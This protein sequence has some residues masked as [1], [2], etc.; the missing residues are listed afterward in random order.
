MRGTC[1]SIPL[2]NARRKFLSLLL[3]LFFLV[4]SC[5][6]PPHR[7]PAHS[8]QTSQEN[9]LSALKEQYELRLSDG[10]KTQEI[11]QSIFADF[12]GEGQSSPKPVLLFTAGPMGA[13]KTFVLEA[14]AKAGYY[15]KER[16]ETV[17]PDLIEPKIPEY[18]EFYS[19]APEEAATILHK[20]S[21]QIADE[22][23]E[24]ALKSGKDIIVDGS[25]RNA[26]WYQGEFQRIRREY[27]SYGILI[28]YT[29]ASS[30]KILERI[31]HR[32]SDPK[33]GRFTPKELALRSLEE[34]EHSIEIL[35]DYVDSTL[36]VD[37]EEKPFFESMYQKGKTR[38]LRIEIPTP[39]QASVS[40]PNPWI[41]KIMENPRAPIDHG[42]P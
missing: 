40:K 20:E 32:A 27:P 13:G 36:T 28:L 35:R 42:R 21:G 34:V 7:S 15:E 3:C 11:H 14:L 24:R 2:P 38:S 39:N 10:P 19:L 9:A 41:K 26:Q 18:R 29:R 30:S 17:N 31:A 8:G 1:L 23:L 4:G 25:L 6:S 12:V 37:N 22:L 16:F 33:D 5:A